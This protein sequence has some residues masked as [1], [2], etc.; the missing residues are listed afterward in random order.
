M[1]INTHEKQIRL[2]ILGLEELKKEIVHRSDFD[3]DFLQLCLRIFNKI[4]SKKFNQW[5]VEGPCQVKQ[6]QF[7]NRKSIFVKGVIVFR[8][9]ETLDGKNF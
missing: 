2:V 4:Q 7:S 5:L 6:I 3:H 8:K 1:N 9:S